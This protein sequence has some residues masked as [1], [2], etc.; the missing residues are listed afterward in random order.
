MNRSLLSHHRS[1]RQDFRHRSKKSITMAKMTGARPSPFFVRDEV[2]QKDSLAIISLKRDQQ[3]PVFLQNPEQATGDTISNTRFGSFPHSTLLGKPWGSQIIATNVNANDTK[4]G[5]KRK[6]EPEKDDPQEDQSDVLP[7]A[8]E[9]ASRGFAHILPPTPE[10]WTVSLPHRTQVVYTP[11]YSLILQKLKAR[12]GDTV[13]E[14]G[15]GSGSFTHASARAV[16][17]GDTTGV[18]HNQAN[19]HTT[20]R[21]QR[22]GKVCSF[23]YHEP[24]AK[25]LQD[26]VK[27]HNLD[28]VVTVTHRDVYQDGFLLEDGMSPQADVI[29]LDLPEPRRALEHLT[30][31][32]ADGSISALNPKSPARLCTFSP[33]IEQVQQTVEAMQRLGWVEISTVEVQHKRLDVRRDMVSL[34]YEGL[35]GVNASA[36]NVE[37]AV[38]KLKELDAKVSQFHESSKQDNKGDRM[39]GKKSKKATNASLETKKERLNRIKEEDKERKVWREG[40]LVHKTE[41]ELKTHTSYLTFAVLP[42]LWTSE[43]EENMLRKW[44]NAK[45]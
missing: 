8:Y 33:C 10:L 31:S 7:P 1:L 3:M 23:E 20:S 6:R 21:R 41:P 39:A 25:Q 34:N 24:R 38:A 22:H 35:R 12:P 29:F 5:R 44:I 17:N 18:D 9:A 32:P 42:Q 2:T 26:E 4:K 13:I 27:D 40:R 28:D 43:D 36:A 11:D 45:P 30:R 15:A 16:F 19:G 14:A 37:E